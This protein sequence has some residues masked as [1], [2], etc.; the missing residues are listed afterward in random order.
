MDSLEFAPLL[1]ALVTTD[2]P[3]AAVWEYLVDLWASIEDRDKYF[4]EGE[5]RTMY[6][7]KVLD[8]VYPELYTEILPSCC[9]KKMLDPLS[10][11]MPLV[12]MD[13]LSIREAVLL[14]RDVPGVA[15]FTFSFSGLPSD[16]NTYRERVFKFIS[17]RRRELKDMSAIVLSGDEVAVRCPL[18]D[19]ELENMVG[20][21]SGHSLMEIYEYTKSSLL[22]ILDELGTDRVLVTSDH[23]YIDA[24]THF[25]QVGRT[26]ADALRNVFDGGRCALQE[27]DASSLVKKGYVIPY[28]GYYLARGRYAW[29]TRGKY[30]VILHGGVSL[31]ECLVPLMTVEM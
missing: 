31:L 8:A 20:A 10:L 6:L 11:E 1:E 19:S 16:T 14:S 13:G 21:V 2:D 30:K 15:E 23:G 29:P 22:A 25:W 4:E 28:G 9:T 12:W 18:P 26:T 24:R 17:G 3:V 7:E 5:R 27:T